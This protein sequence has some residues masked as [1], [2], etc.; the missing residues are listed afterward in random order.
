LIDKTTPFQHSAIVDVK[1]LTKPLRNI[2]VVSNATGSE[3]KVPAINSPTNHP[4]QSHSH[5]KKTKVPANRVPVHSKRTKKHLVSVQESEP[6]G[7]IYFRFKV[8]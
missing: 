2:S 5:H 8:Y 7:K 6:E 4:D 1:I 3:V